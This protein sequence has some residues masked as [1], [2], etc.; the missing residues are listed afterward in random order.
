MYRLILL[1]GVISLTIFVLTHKDYLIREH[2]TN[3][4]PSLYSLQKEIKETD[5]KVE[6]LTQEFNQMKNQA[7]AQA[8]QAAAAKAQ[9]SAA[10]YS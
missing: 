7:S 10:K 3:L 5:S 4:P 9:L 1:V 6:K 8:G 2:L